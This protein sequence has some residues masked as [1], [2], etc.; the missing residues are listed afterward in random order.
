MIEPIRIAFEVACPAPHAF[1]VWTAR[2]GQWWPADHTVTA[3]PDLTV[4]L[5]R[6]PADG[7]SSGP[8]TAPSTT[9]AR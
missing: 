4:V 1:E 2:I 6:R 9:G 7:S 8:A 5:E 3:E